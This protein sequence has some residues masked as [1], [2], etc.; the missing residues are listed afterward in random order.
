MASLRCLV[1]K[2]FLFNVHKTRNLYDPKVILWN[3]RPIFLT[4]SWA[5]YRLCCKIYCSPILSQSGEWYQINITITIQLPRQLTMQNLLPGGK[6]FLENMKVG[7]R[8]YREKENYE[9]VEKQ[10][11]LWE[12]KIRIWRKRFLITLESKS[13]FGL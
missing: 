4:L 2:Y 3:P 1:F 11:D 5:L 13:H 12:E 7:T 8:P 10:P 9:V 6:H